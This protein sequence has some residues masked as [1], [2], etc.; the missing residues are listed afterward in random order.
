MPRYGDDQ[1]EECGGI[2]A[3]GAVLCVNCLVRT[4]TRLEDAVAEKDSKIEELEEKLEMAK[5]TI[6]RLLDHIAENERYEMD[7]QRQRWEGLLEKA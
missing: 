6:Q 2:R 4:I 1:C 3:A 7:L 5:T